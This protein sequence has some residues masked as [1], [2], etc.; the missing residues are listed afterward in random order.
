MAD[1]ITPGPDYDAALWGAAVGIRRERRFLRVTGKAPGDMLNG[2]L[3]NSLP[4][5][6]DAEERGMLRGSV[7]YSAL[8][9]PKGRMITDLRVFRDPKEGFVLDLPGSGVED[10]LAHFKKF[11]PPRL[12]KVEDRSEEL[13]LIT[14][15]GPEAPALLAEVASRMGLP[16]SVEEMMEL[17]E[18]EEI[19]VPLGLGEPFRVTRNGESH[20][21]GW[22]LLLSWPSA[23]E[24]R[25]R[26]DSVGAIPLTEASLEILRVEKGRPAFGR[27][28]NQD[29]IP[30][31][32]GIQHRAIDHQK[33]CYTGQE[34]IIRIRDR[35]HVNKELRGFFLG[36]TSPTSSGHELFKPGRDKSVGWIT[37]AVVS[38][39]FGQAIA[40]GY[41][42]RGVE[43]AE[44]VR[45]GS[46]DGY[47]V[48][49]FSLS[50][51]GWVLD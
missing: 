15:L 40:L 21:A 9:T 16:G 34:V 38:P 47:R 49:A 37:S 8:L 4:R 35:G 42:Q 43:L 36:D 6:F 30:T 46:V 3:T 20:A 27:D 31:E 32:A 13:A 11:L 17:V 48:Q 1:A 2:L 45:M 25:D 33:G 10:T 5:P 41:L 18:G 29:T 22:D 50:D 28:M 39:A 24:L 44:D 19:L 12:A 51:E 26:L 14:L 7:V 23:E